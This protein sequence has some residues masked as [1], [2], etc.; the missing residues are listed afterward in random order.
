MT[1]GSRLPPYIPYPLFL[2][3]SSLSMTACTLFALLLHRALLSQKNGWADEN[4]RVYVIYPVDELCEAMKRGRTAVRDA[5][6]ELENAGLLERCSQG[7]N[8]PNRI[9]LRLP[10]DETERGPENRPSSGRKTGGWAAGKPVA[11]KYIKSKYNREEKNA[12]R[13][14]LR[15][16]SYQGEDSL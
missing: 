13:N 14:A 15:D 12:G 7:Y 9:Y 10:K 16:Y 2:L 1:A 5:L 11:S 4:G 6:S 8:K 3:E